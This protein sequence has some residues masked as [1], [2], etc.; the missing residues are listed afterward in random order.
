MLKPESVNQL[1]EV[2]TRFF[3]KYPRIYNIKKAHIDSMKEVS[4]NT[5]N[6]VA[7]QTILDLCARRM[8]FHSIDNFRS[9][10]EEWVSGNTDP[11]KSLLI[12][13]TNNQHQAE[14]IQFFE[15][16]KFSDTKIAKDNG[17]PQTKLNGPKLHALNETFGFQLDPDTAKK[18]KVLSL[19]EEV[20]TSNWLTNVV[21]KE[22][23]Q[24]YS[25]WIN[26]QR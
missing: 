21:R 2:L 5:G 19:M 25:E 3:N 22:V 11:L 12:K 1:L 16:H 9:L 10:L 20:A 14:I 13:H 18:L 6:T 7:Y 23:E 15:Q 26:K 4:E 17:A 8:S 24:K